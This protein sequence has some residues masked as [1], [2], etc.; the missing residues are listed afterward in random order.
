MKKQKLVKLNVDKF[1]SMEEC[2]VSQLSDIVGGKRDPYEQYDLGKS[3]SEDNPPETSVRP[4]R[5]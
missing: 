2:N 5:P 1:L 4:V 3:G